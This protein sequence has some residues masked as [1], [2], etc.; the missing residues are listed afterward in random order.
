MIE[1]TSDCPK[2]MADKYRDYAHLSQHESFGIDFVYSEVNRHSE[3]VVVAPHGGG[4]EP[5]TSEVATAIAGQNYSRY[6]FEGRKN[7]ENFALHI[8]SE[9]FDAPGCRP[10]IQ[11]SCVAITIHGE[12]SNEP[13]VFIGGRDR[14]WIALLQD[15]LLAAGFVAKKH[16]DPGL[17]GE[18]PDNICNLGTSRAGVQLEISQGLR[19]QFFPSLTREGRK[20]P[21]NRFHEFVSVV[22]FCC[23]SVLPE[24]GSQVSQTGC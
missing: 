12:G 23:P 17:Q 15:A 7:S 8:S 20:H 18:H 2:P 24:T 16:P 14:Q 22:R 1:A 19:T 3:M 9:R 13:V 6:L 11:S 5:G 10:L 4:I 21:T